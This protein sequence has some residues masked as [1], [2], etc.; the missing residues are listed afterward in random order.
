MVDEPVVGPS[1]P[2]PQPAGSVVKVTESFSALLLLIL[3]VAAALLTIAAT[4][5]RL[6]YHPDAVMF[7]VEAQRPAAS[8]E[9]AAGR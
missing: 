5:G 3:A 6:G 2:V 1:P 4:R 8:S 9:S 7:S